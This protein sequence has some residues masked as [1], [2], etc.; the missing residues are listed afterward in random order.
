[1]RIAQ[2]RGIT[3]QLPAGTNVYFRDLD[4]GEVF[5]L[6]HWRVEY[7]AVESEKVERWPTEL[8]IEGR[9]RTTQTLTETTK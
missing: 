8:V 3:P 9:R 1:M 5:R 6:L 7:T 4:T 2:L